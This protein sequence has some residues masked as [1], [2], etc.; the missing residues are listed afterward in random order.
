[1]AIGPASRPA[2]TLALRLVH[3][4][5]RLVDATSGALTATS[6]V[7]TIA[8]L[9]ADVC[10]A[11]GQ[12]SGGA[13]FAA[14]SVD[15]G[16][17]WTQQAI[18]SD[19]KSLASLSC[20]SSEACVAVGSTSSGAVL[21]A[22]KNSGASWTEQTLPSTVT[23]LSSV[24]CATM[25]ICWAVGRAGH[26]AALLRGSVAGSWALTPVP[27]AV[28]SLSAVGCTAGLTPTTCIAVGSA[29]SAPAALDTAAGSPWAETLISGNAT[30]FASAAC[31]GTSKT[32]PICTTLAEIDGVWFEASSYLAESETPGQ[33]FVPNAPGS[34]APGSGGP[35]FT[36]GTLAAGVSSCTPDCTPSNTIVV[37]NVM[38][39]LAGLSGSGSGTSPLNE[40]IT[41]AYVT[42]TQPS[43][44]AATSTALSPVWYLGAAN[45]GLIATEVLTPSQRTASDA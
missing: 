13:A 31:T 20:T 10:E 18:P 37:N 16:T 11:V 29:G 2:P 4:Q 41:S 24:S 30:A 26:T 34:N 25:R 42:A 9:T 27:A 22:T 12:T 36:P 44:I 33:W 28:T 32:S 14:G 3:D 17:T 8:C 7:T 21:V 40:S 19:V 39:V 6:D 35:S 1:L 15:G 5:V 23:S 43:P 45:R 38:K